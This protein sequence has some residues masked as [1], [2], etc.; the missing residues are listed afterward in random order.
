MEEGGRKVSV[1]RGGGGGGGRGGDSY[2]DVFT[3][4]SVCCVAGFVG[5]S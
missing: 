5:V 1:R 3:G 4:T 2:T